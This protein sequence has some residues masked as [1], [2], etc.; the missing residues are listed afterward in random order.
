MPNVAIIF[1]A[2]KKRLVDEPKTAGEEKCRKKLRNQ[3]LFTK[4]R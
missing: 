4:Q 2:H 1:T 3:E